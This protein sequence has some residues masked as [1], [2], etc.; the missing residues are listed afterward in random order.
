[1][2]LVFVI[3]PVQTSTFQELWKLERWD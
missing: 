3:E 2:K 1:M